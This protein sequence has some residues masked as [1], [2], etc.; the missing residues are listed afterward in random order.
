MSKR[1]VPEPWA[2]AMRKA[3][4]V[5]KRWGNPSWSELGRRVGVHASTITRM[6]DGGNTDLDTVGKVADELRIEVETVGQWIQAALPVH[7]LY[8]APPESRLLDDEEREVLTRLIITMAKGKAGNELGKRSA[9]KR[10][11]VV[12]DD[13][14]DEAARRSDGDPDDGDGPPRNRSTKPG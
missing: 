9:Q 13:A 14:D 7:D 3:G 8:K 12:P 1:E 4:V 2:S 5:D 6:V 10:L 11:S